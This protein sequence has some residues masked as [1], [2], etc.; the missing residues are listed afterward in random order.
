LTLRAVAQLPPSITLKADE[1]RRSLTDVTMADAR[2]ALGDKVTVMINAYDL[3]AETRKAFVGLA[4][5]KG[6]QTYVGTLG[7][8]LD[9][10]GQEQS[11]R[12]VRHYI[13]TSTNFRPALV[14]WM[15]LMFETT[16]PWKTAYPSYRKV[17][18]ERPVDFLPKALTLLHPVATGEEADQWFSLVTEAYSTASSPTER[19]FCFI[20]LSFQ[21]VTLAKVPDG[22]KV[23]RKLSDWIDDLEKKET[24]AR[25]PGIHELGSLRFLV[26]FACNDFSRAADAAPGTKFRSMRPLM[27]LLARKPEEARRSVVELRKNSTL[28]ETERNGIESI[29]ALLDE[30]EAATK[31]SG[32]TVP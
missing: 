3:T 9:A 21:A 30:L 23:L 28:S 4:D 20:P 16:G 19:S 7:I 18:H 10:V 29:K 32:K 15:D 24:L 22:E 8:D 13:S 17:A 5:D 11:M 25:N 2:K 27:L 12:L 6:F 26:A 31:S 14:G 1:F